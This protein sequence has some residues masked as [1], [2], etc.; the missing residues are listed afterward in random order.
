MSE[1]E[2]QPPLYDQTSVVLEP[3]RIAAKK[4]LSPSVVHGLRAKVYPNLLMEEFVAEIETAVYAQRL[5]TAT[6]IDRQT[7]TFMVPATTWGMFKD[8][9]AQSWWLRWWVKRHPPKIQVLR[10]TVVLHTEWRGYATFPDMSEVI[11]DKTLGAPIFV[12]LKRRR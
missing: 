5:T 8:R 7:V 2:V 9:H 11:E 1:P 3:L 6:D 4:R 10:E 12:S